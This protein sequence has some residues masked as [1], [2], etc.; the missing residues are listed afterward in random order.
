MNTKTT[1]ASEDPT[2]SAILPPG[3]QDYTPKA[4]SSS[5][6]VVFAFKLFSI[7]ALLIGLLWLLDRAL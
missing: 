4:Y 5:E 6:N 3:D 1:P 7:V 2:T